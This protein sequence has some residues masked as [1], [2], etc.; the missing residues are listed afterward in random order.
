MRVHV[1]S[2]CL[3]IEQ[4]DA[5]CTPTPPPTLVW[6]SQPG[7]LAPERHLSLPQSLPHTFSSSLK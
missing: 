7:V 2:W 4:P 6:E 1:E 3:E 5:P